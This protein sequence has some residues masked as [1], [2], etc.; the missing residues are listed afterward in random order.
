MSCR[1]SA[2]AEGLPATGKIQT[3]MEGKPWNMPPTL[4]TLYIPP[5]PLGGSGLVVDAQTGSW[6][7]K[8]LDF[9]S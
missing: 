7:P 8:T 1:A 9:L 5:F 6:V 2:S 3:Q 4:Q